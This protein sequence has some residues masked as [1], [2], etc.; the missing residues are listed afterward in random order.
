MSDM[1]TEKSER[2]FTFVMEQK[3]PRGPLTRL[4]SESSAV[5]NYAD[6]L[7][8]PGSSFL[9]IGSDHHLNREQVQEL[10]QRMQH[11]LATGQLAND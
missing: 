5:G 9:W 6:S 3:Y 7:D 8:K 10:I 1:Q 2:G 4:I 11:W